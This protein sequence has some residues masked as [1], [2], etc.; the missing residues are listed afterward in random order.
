MDQVNYCSKQST[1]ILLFPSGF[2][3]VNVVKELLSKG[4]KVRGTVRSKAK[5]EYLVKKFTGGHFE[6][7]SVRI[8]SEH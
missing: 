7:V 2:I 5:G 6:Y 4:Y 1:D 8:F 3:A